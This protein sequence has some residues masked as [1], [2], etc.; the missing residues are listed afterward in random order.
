[1]QRNTKKTT[2]AT[3]IGGYGHTFCELNDCI[4]GGCFEAYGM[5]AIFLK[6]ENFLHYSITGSLYLLPVCP[7]AGSSYRLLEG[8]STLQKRN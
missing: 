3:T 4:A 8:S 2:I 6:G 1:M 5:F 7:A